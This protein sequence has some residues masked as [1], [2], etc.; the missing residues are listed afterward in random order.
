MAAMDPR[1]G[2]ENPALFVDTGV[3]LLIER[4]SDLGASVP[5]MRIVVAGAAQVL[6]DLQ[7]FDVASRNYAALRKLLAKNGLSTFA[8]EVGG[9]IP[10]TMCLDVGTGA[11]TIQSQG[12]QRQ[13]AAP[14][15]AFAAAGTC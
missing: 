8:E 15:P 14:V 12:S 6:N 5:S 13:L 2:Q 9:E 10:R 3:L 4:L 1:R 7:S 11:V